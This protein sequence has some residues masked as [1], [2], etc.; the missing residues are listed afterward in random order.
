M[1]EKIKKI[2]DNH[3]KRIKALEKIFIGNET[4]KLKKE[5][6]LKEFILLKKPRDDVQK[7]L[8]IGFYLEKYENLSSFNV[9]DLENG[10]R[11]AKEKVPRNINDKVNLNIKNGHMME[12][13][14]K[15]DNRK[16]WVLTGSGERFIENDFTK[17]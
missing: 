2:L 10:Y 6:S 12:A 16:A 8:V 11:A 14:E 3:E 4:L 13:K 7:T 17:E 1:D 9:K 5:I 15:K